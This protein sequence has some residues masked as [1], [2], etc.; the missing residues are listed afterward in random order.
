MKKH[1]KYP[2]RSLLVTEL[3]SDFLPFNTTTYSIFC[4]SVMQ[5]NT[6]DP[7]TARI[8]VGQKQQ[9]KLKNNEINN[10]K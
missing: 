4:I 8:Q 6:C 3:Q 1:N 5:I 9:R 10:I 7:F 2:C